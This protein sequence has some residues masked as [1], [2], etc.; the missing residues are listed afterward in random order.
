MTRWRAALGAA[1]VL[2]GGS[3]ATSLDDGTGW[4][5]RAVTLAVV[6][7]PDSGTLRVSGRL[8]AVAP[9]GGSVGPTLVLA[10]D[11]MRFDS[12][13]VDGASITYSTGRD[14]A[15][16]R[17]AQPM[18][19]GSA[20]EVRFAVRAPR[21]RLARSVAVGADGA[22]AS[23]FG[24]WYPWLASAKGREPGMRA[25]GVLTLA[26]PDGWSGLATG[27]LTD[28][29]RAG[30]WRR[31]RWES[32]Q[33]LVWS[34]IAAP[35]HVTR[36][37]VDTTD[38]AVHLM[39]RQAKKAAEFARAIPGMVRT[40]ERAYGAYP[41]ATFGIAGIPAGIAPPGIGGRSEMGYFLTHEHALDADT[42]DVP[43]FAHELAHMWWANTVLSD[44][45][46]DDMVD[47]GMASYGA[48]LVVE[49]RYGRAGARQYMREGSI[50]N[51][52]RTF[53]HLWRIGGDERL[54]ADFA[55][56]PSYS[57]G[58]WVYEMLRDRI[59]DSLFFAT[60]HRIV[61][62][63]AGRS[64][65]LPDLRAEFE[66]D[67]PASA[68]LP[69]FFHDWLDR[70]GAPVLDVHWRATRQS[71]APAAH[72]TLV[73][74]T[75]PYRFP[76]DID[77][78]SRAGTRRSR[79]VLRDSMQSFDLPARGTPTGIRID[80]EHHVMLWEPKFGPIRGV[81]APFSAEETRR[82]LRNDLAW[83]RGQYGVGR[84]DV[85]IVRRGAVE[86]TSAAGAGV[87]DAREPSSSPHA[88]ALGRLGEVAA[89]LSSD[90]VLVSRTDA[91]ID[92]LAAVW[93]RVLNAASQTE[94]DVLHAIT[95]R[96]DSASDPF[97]ATHRGGL[98]FSLA[99]KKGALRLSLVDVSAGRTLVL[100]GYPGTGVGCVIVSDTERV[101]VG[102]ATQIAQRL[103]FANDWP[104][105]PGRD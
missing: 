100:L 60:L 63:R 17:L 57:K 69:R 22:F 46:G 49:S 75:A 86:S 92:A 42:V 94:R 37:R 91:D 32:R 89:R 76:L 36:H 73:Q 70:P 8:S 96:G 27:R 81:T 6:A 21:A 56:L 52:A 28:S 5:L 64:T 90:R 82:W 68:D 50:P 99:T 43:I 58:A 55:T 105:F 101:G 25:P 95:T 83:L 20:I 78:E 33:P 98:G 7:H 14:S 85:A 84:V 40:L 61:R 77:V 15:R 35:Y 47:E 45:P 10:P 59:G 12:V 66:R 97:R 80:P 71:D 62:E 3:V 88:W 39:P 24:N 51:S 87:T 2:T 30:G 104:E 74:R 11:A 72:V 23:W 44:P 26:I 67:A 9:D 102:L 4:S 34:F 18:R 38:V 29:S 48:T 13:A 65:T 54:M 31:E 16:V 93:A 53:F 41:F 1:L 103:A 19:A 79:I